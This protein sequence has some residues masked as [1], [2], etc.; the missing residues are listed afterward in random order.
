MN[1]RTHRLRRIA[2]AVALGVG[3]VGGVVGVAAS[4]AGATT[5]H[6]STNNTISATTAPVIPST[7]S[8][9]SAGNLKAVLHNHSGKVVDTSTLTLAVA[10]HGGGLVEWASAPTVSGATLGANIYPEATLHLVIATMAV[11][12]TRTVTVTGVKYDTV[13]AHG[14]VRVTPTWKKKTGTVTATIKTPVGTFATTPYAVN[15]VAT[16]VTPATPGTQTLNAT[17][18]PTV[19]PTGSGQAAGTWTVTFTGTKG[20]GWTKNTTFAI[21]VHEPAPTGLNC[22]TAAGYVLVT[23]TPSAK[24]GTSKNVSTTPTFVVSTKGTGTTCTGLN[25]NEVTITFTNTGTFTGTHHATNK[26]TIAVSGVKYNLVQGTS[27]HYGDVGVNYTTTTGFTSAKTYTTATT[28]GMSNADVAA[29]VMTGDTPA[30]TYTPSSYDAAI[31]P[32]NVI[33]QVAGSIPSGE[34]VCFS[35]SNGTFNAANAAKAA[36]KSGNGVVTPT[37]KYYD[38]ATTA[39]TSGNATVAAFKVKTA[40]TATH[41]GTYSVSGLAINA[42]ATSGP[43]LAFGQYSAN[44]RCNGGTSP[45]GEAVAVVISVPQFQRI[46][47]STAAATAAAQL[48][49][50][51]Q[52]KANTAGSC[53]GTPVTTHPTAST[54]TTAGIGRRAVILANETHFADALS[55]QYLAGRLHTGTLLTKATSLPSVTLNTLRLEGISHVYVIGGNLAVSTTVVNQLETTPSYSCG[56]AAVRKTAGGSTRYLTVTRISGPT[57]YDTAEMVATYLAKSAV[58]KGSFPAAYVGVNKTGGNGQYNDT[59]G[60]ASPAGLGSNQETGILADGQV[61]QDA[62]S[63]GPFSYADGYPVLLTTPSKLSPQALSAFTTDTITQVIVMGG[64]DAVSNTVV[65]SLEAAG[66]HVLRIAGADYTDTAVQAADFEAAPAISGLDWI[67]ADSGHTFAVARGNGFSDG[68]AGAVITGNKLQPLLLTENPTTVGP[69]LTA[70]LKHAGTKGP[71]VDQATTA[72]TADYR[73]T[74][75]LIFGGTLA[76]T[77]A[78]VKTIQTDL[79]TG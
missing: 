33:E 7:G 16:A 38:G 48:L 66:M 56:G 1:H 27:Q 78:V 58:G 72:P 57:Q 79:S 24:I 26:F 68:L 2:A 8:N 5:A 73:L 52:G 55:S 35:L 25:R 18:T 13:A 11:G 49:H 6:Q 32:L 54:N 14:T 50:E 10:A 9:N 65:T 37:V 36:V 63:A 39:V 77:P 15:A 76:I 46:A 75:A 22:T 67:P 4:S 42:P 53:P 64:P 29:V 74:S 61:F 62:M 30:K 19:K 43:I 60:T 34:Y 45:A 20:E 3:M 59:S 70:F 40:S 28:F 23:G 21:K 69:Y 17:A 51:Y 47:G 41:A 12:A 71:G 31:S 44:K